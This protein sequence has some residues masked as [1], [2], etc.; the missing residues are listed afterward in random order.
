MVILFL[1]ICILSLVP[2][3]TPRKT[4]HLGRNEH[5]RCPD[6]GLKICISHEKE[7]R[8]HGK[9]LIPGLEQEMYK[10]NFEHTVVPE[11]KETI[12]EDWMM[13]KDAIL[14]SVSSGVSDS[15]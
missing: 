13:S 9:L 14:S 6:C 15:L 11:S 3:K 2:L 8:L 1:K 5:S 4:G 10:M 12:K 7:L